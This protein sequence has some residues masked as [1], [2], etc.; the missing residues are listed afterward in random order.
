MNASLRTSLPAFSTSTRRVSNS[1]PRRRSSSISRSSLRSSTSRKYLLKKYMAIVKPQPASVG[2][3][4]P[5]V[6]TCSLFYY[7]SWSG[8][9]VSPR[10]LRNDSSSPSSALAFVVRQN[11][12][13]CAVSRKAFCWRLITRRGF[14][15][16]CRFSLGRPRPTTETCG[17]NFKLAFECPVKRGFGLIADFRCDLCHCVTRRDE[18]LRSQL[19]SPAR[20]VGHRSFVEEMAEAL[21]EHRS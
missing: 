6:S 11:A 1:L 18:H 8:R 16:P 17:R 14:R 3:G 7:L 21:G 2:T 15:L 5:R 19:Q 12:S 4:K 13:A 9:L 10:T 20:E